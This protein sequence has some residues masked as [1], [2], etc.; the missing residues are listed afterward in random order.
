MLK[1]YGRQHLG[2]EVF[3]GVGTKPAL[4]DITPQHAAG[5]LVIIE[6]G[7]F[8]AH[9]FLIAGERLIIIHWPDPVFT[10]PNNYVCTR[11]ICST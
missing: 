6:A 2:G 7:S 8:F 11:Y 5:N 4:P 10:Q 3:A 1:G 9:N